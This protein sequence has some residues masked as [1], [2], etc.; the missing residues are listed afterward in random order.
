MEDLQCYRMY[1]DGSW[2]DALGGR[3]FASL[4]P[5]TAK[6]WAKVPE[7][8]VSDVDRAVRAAHKAYTEGPWAKMTATQRGHTPLSTSPPQAES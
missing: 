4:N 1:I 5:S 8:D 7:A 2:V 3:T 6:P